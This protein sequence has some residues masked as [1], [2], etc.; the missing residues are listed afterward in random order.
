MPGPGPVVHVGAG[1]TCTHLGL[2]S[3]QS[4]NTRVH[5]NG[6]PVVTVADVYPV[7]ACPFQVP[8]PTPSGTRPSPCVRIQWMVPAARVQVNLQFVIVQT[9]TG[10]GVSA[11]Q[12]AQGPPI[13]S[14]VQPRVIAT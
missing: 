11:E 5:M 10:A 8:A 7:A 9:S 3:P 13:L 6:M 2:V 1:I 4:S 14:A 12:L